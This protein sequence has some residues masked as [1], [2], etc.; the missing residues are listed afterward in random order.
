MII[1]HLRPARF[2]LGRVLA[3]PGR[4]ASA[5]ELASSLKNFLIGTLTCDWGEV[6]SHDAN[7]NEISLRRG[8]RLL[9]S[10]TTG[11]GERLWIITEAD[12]FATTLLLPEEY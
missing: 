6:D 7:A 1:R 10:Y 9:S 4:L 12:R 2:A 8:F 3:T 11:A 5:R